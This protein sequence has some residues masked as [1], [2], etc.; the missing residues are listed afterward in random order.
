MVGLRYM[1]IRISAHNECL[2]EDIEVWK[3]LGSFDEIGCCVGLYVGSILEI[4]RSPRS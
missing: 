1:L 2:E 3:R 4:V